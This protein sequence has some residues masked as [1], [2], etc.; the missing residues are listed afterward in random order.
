MA[1]P[2]GPDT[3]S[4]RRIS[5]QFVCLFET[6]LLFHSCA[7]VG[8]VFRWVRCDSGEQDVEHVIHIGGVSGV[9]SRPYLCRSEAE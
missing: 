1:Y 7:D 6:A 3:I 2:G 5:S 8:S 4:S 9:R